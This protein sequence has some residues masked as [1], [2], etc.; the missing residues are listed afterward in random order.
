MITK[1]PGEIERKTLHEVVRDM[2]GGHLLNDG[3][4]YNLYRN[5]VIS[6]YMTEGPD[7]IS[8]KEIMLLQALSIQDISRKIDSI[9]LD[10]IADVLGDISETLDRKL[11]GK[12][13]R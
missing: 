12:G 9:G 10:S 13:E 2:V 11:K 4:F 5:A 6:K 7:G 3:D 8:E 1:D